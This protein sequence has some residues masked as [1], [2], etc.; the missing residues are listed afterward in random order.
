MMLLS[1][2]Q[3]GS[4]TENLSEIAFD[5]TFEITRLSSNACFKYSFPN[6]L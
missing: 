6:E 2:G 4:A 1:Y 5:L 3:L